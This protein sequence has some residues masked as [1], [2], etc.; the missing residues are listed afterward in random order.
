M[1][2]I[3]Q[4]SGTT[5]LEVILFVG[6]LGIISTT[7]VAVFMA[8]QDAR[9]RQ[10]SVADLEQQGTQIL[11]KMRKTMRSAE[12]V[13][14]PLSGETGSLLLMQMA[15]NREYPTILAQV[16]Q[17]VVLVQKSGTSALLTS[18]VSIK[19]LVFQ[20]VGGGNVRMTFD[21]S[22]VIPTIEHH[23]YS[24]SFNGTVTLF[25]DDQ[26]DAG[27]CGTCP[28]PMCIAGRYTWYICESD[29]CSQSDTTLPC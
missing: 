28:L 14:I 25:P 2:C 18:T 23:V 16:G 22:T 7:T 15:Q 13:L 4:R 27:G 29:I 11:E 8:T 3:T 24:R 12:K 1:K 26:S 17:S 20:N 21:L 6:I 10:K 19:K 9:I 5:L